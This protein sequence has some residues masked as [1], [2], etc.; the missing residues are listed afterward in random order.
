MIHTLLRLQDR[1]PVASF[2]IGGR[3]IPNTPLRRD[4]NFTTDPEDQEEDVNETE[5]HTEEDIKK[6]HK[7]F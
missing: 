1:F 5:L 3:V 4:I 2:Y 6:I 7:I